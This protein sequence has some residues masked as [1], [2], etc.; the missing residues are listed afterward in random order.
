MSL[1]QIEMVNLEQLI[2]NEHPY[3]KL[4]AAIDFD[5]IVKS[6]SLLPKEAGATG[7]TINRLVMCLILQF[8]EDLSD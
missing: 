3:R 8:M 6:I 1:N 7:Y 4:K 5:K 2:A